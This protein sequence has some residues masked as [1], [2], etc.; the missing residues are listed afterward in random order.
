MQP[1]TFELFDLMD[2]GVGLCSAVSLE[3]L[4]ANSALIAWLSLGPNKNYLSDHIN[5]ENLARIKRSIEKKRKYRFCQTYLIHS[6]EDTIEFICSTISLSNNQEFLLI[7]A[8]VNNSDKHLKALAKNHA[9]LLEKNN[10]LLLK[11]KLKAEEANNAKDKFLAAMSHE[12]RTPLNGILGMVQQ[13]EKS[14]LTLSQNHYLNTIN[15]SGQQLLAVINQVLDYSKIDSS[16]VI[17]H[18]VVSDISSIMTQVSQI[19]GEKLLSDRNVNFHTQ[20]SPDIPL[21]IVDDIRLKQILINLVSN[22]LKFTHQGEVH[23]ILELSST[24]AKSCELI[25]KVI[26]TGIGISDERVEHIFEPFIQH[27]FSTTREYGG[28]GLGLS[29]CKQLVEI[30]GGAISV[31]SQLNVGSQFMVNLS[32]NISHDTEINREDS[33]TDRSS[34]DVSIIKGKR[35]LIVDD[36]AINREIIKMP[37]EEFDTQLYFAEDGVQAIEMFK[38]HDIDLVLM[39]CLMPVM[40]GF[41]ATKAI[42]KMEAIGNRVPI[43]AV[44]ASISEELTLSCKQAGMDEVMLKPFDFEELIKKISYSLIN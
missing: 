30:M 38:K 42:R 43:F 31:T 33:L 19:C 16:E 29:I 44:T 11:E 14:N 8:S 7:Q 32:L 23:L 15:S 27:S 40:D 28:T 24:K 12:L 17:L 20:I 36:I 35:I 5:A 3:V 9:V 37:L 39:D 18:P 25:F 2:Y 6:R 1:V 21:V 26:D 41:D 13:L 34:Y 22:A 4:E 10:Q